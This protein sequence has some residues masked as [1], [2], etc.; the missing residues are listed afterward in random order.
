MLLKFN[1]TFVV[2]NS[3]LDIKIIISTLYEHLI[4]KY[5]LIKLSTVRFVKTASNLGLIW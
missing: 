1:I 5:N 4:L 3:I 2:E